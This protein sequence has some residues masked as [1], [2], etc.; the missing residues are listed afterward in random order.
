MGP[1]KQHQSTES[2]MLY[3]VV[4]YV[5]CVQRMLMSIFKLQTNKR[6]GSV[7]ARC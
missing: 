2:Y 6:E 4:Q 3:N 5:G 1:N 7:Q